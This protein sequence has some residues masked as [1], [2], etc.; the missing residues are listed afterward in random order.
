M[1]WSISASAPSR[2]SGPTCGPSDG[3]FLHSLSSFAPYLSL[4]GLHM[5]DQLC[6]R[7]LKGSPACFLRRACGSLLVW[8]RIPVELIDVAEES[9]LNIKEHTLILYRRFNC[10]I[11]TEARYSNT[12]QDDA[13]FRLTSFSQC[14]SFPLPLRIFPQFDATIWYNSPPCR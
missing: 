12:P 5:L 2:Q 11:Q 3:S 4:P 13:Q 6:V 9:A 10:A 8:T 1:G 14:C 7:S